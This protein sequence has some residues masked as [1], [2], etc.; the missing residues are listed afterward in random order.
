MLSVDA[1]AELPVADYASE[2]SWEATTEN[3][4]DV[5]WPTEGLWSS[6]VQYTNMAQGWCFY[7]LSYNFISMGY[8]QVKNEFPLFQKLFPLIS[9]IHYF[10]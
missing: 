5:F 6:W 9:G 4:E 1:L 7:E 3:S 2:I 10:W 8:Y